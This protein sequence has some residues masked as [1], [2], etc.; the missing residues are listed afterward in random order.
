MFGGGCCGTAGNG[1]KSYIPKC[2]GLVLLW[3]VGVRLF[4]LYC[5]GIY[6]TICVR[7]ARGVGSIW[8]WDYGF[9][10]VGGMYL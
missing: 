4:L 9:S 1:G 3:L 8:E 7:H 6:M 2:L 5:I 10:Q